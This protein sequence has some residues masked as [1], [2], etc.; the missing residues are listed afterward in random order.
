[1]AFGVFILLNLVLA[2]QNPRLSI[3]GMWLDARL[4]EPWLS[5][6][7]GVLGLSLIV[8]HGLAGISWLR[9]LTAGVFAGFG[10]LTLASTLS[11]YHSL[12]HG[13][14]ATGLPVPFSALLTAILAL[15]FL[16]VFLWAYCPPLTPPPARVF[17]TSI[18]VAGAFLLITL[19]YVVTY[20]QID[21][22][23]PADAAVVFGAKVYSDGRLCT[24][25]QDRLDTAIELFEQN[26]VQYLIMTGA[27]DPN[28]QSE[29]DVMR[30]YAL[31]GRVPASRI[32]L[33]RTG[34]NTRASAVGCRALLRQHG[35]RHL[36]AVSQYFHCARVKMIFEREGVPCSTVPTC[37]PVRTASTPPRRLSREGFFLFREAVAFPFYMVYYR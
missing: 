29:P 31:R 22:R 32:L 1:M 10:I 15:E 12:H 23:R 19:A 30:E 16:R 8:P 26:A 5:V 9:W 21:F 6:F 33:D 37:S 4:P 2:L 36:L 20:G 13:S 14:V 18:A 3:T 17:L 25:L 28:G 27:R 24:A 11:F 7:A 35:F 34:V